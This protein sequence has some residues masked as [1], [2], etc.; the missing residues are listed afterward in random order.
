MHSN[1]DALR[2]DIA[3]SISVGM[4]VIHFNG[5]GSPV[6]TKTAAA[7]QPQH[8]ERRMPVPQALLMWICSSSGEAWPSLELILGGTL[9][10]RDPVGSGAS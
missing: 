7:G 10:P 2:I 6:Q 3:A 8:G 9:S 1:Q 4:P 5:G